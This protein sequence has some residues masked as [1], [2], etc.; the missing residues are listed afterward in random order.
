[1]IMKRTILYSFAA[2]F[3][4][5]VGLFLVVVVLLKSGLFYLGISPYFHYRLNENELKLIDDAILKFRERVENGR[6]DEIQKELAENQRDESYQKETIAII[7]NNREK[8]GKPLSKEFFRATPPE[9]ASKYYKNTEGA[10]YETWY[11][12]NAENGEFHETFDWTIK[13]KN[14]VKLLGYE[15]SKLQDWEIK[16]REKEK[17]LN[18][19]YPN[20]IR[21]PFGARFIEIRY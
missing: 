1:M 12:T 20:E 13:D 9:S 16:T 15:V 3:L 14:E 2:L 11:F 8:Y 19:N 10:F 17:Y 18:A 7:K 5:V 4:V 21:I 6:F